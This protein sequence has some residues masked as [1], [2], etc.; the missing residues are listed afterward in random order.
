LQSTC[1]SS[2]RQIKPKE[3]ALENKLTSKSEHILLIKLST[4]K[5]YHPLSQEFKTDFTL[6]LRFDHPRRKVPGT[7]PT[8]TLVGQGISVRSQGQLASQKKTKV[9]QALDYF[10]FCAGQVSNYSGA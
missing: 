4:I 2:K 3:K 8:K 6:P 1:L 9:F 10:N 7:S 5:P